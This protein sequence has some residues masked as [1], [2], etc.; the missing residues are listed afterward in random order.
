[1][2]DTKPSKIKKKVY[3]KP[4]LT[5]VRLVAQEAVLGVCKTGNLSNG[6]CLTCVSVGGS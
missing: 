4:Q 2:T 1:M 5:E 6:G 3:T